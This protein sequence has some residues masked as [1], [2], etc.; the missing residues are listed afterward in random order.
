MFAQPLQE[1][2]SLR[3][4]VA[5]RVALRVSG[6][7]YSLILIIVIARYDPEGDRVVMRCCS[8]S[9]GVQRGRKKGNR[10]DERRRGMFLSKKE[11]AIKK[12]G[13]SKLY[14]YLSYDI[15]LC[16]FLSQTQDVEKEGL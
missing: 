9:I 11:T 3:V 10:G 7:T 5:R 8:P 16:K 2:R 1:R 4:T 6:H 13:I 12:F 15:E 14:Y